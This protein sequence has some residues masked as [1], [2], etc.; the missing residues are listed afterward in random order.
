[1]IGEIRDNF[2]ESEYGTLVMRSYDI[3]GNSID[4]FYDASDDLVF[5]LDNTIIANK[6][7]VL[8]VI[9]PDADKKWDEILSEKYN[10]DLETIRP[11]QD[12][13]YQKLDIEYSGLA[14]YDNLINAYKAGDSLDDVLNQLNI[15][16]DSA[17]RH[18]AMTRLNV[19]NDTI[20]KTN[21]TIVK[22]KE[23]IVRLQ[24]RLKTLRAK[25]VDMKKEIGRVSTKKSAAKILRTESQIEATNEKLKRAKKRLES[26]QKRLE[27]ATVDAELASN[28]LNQPSMEIKQPVPVKNKPLVA[29][30]EHEV[31]MISEDAMLESENKAEERYEE[32]ETEE[33]ESDVKPLLEEDPNIVDDNIAFKPIEFNVSDATE[34]LP[35]D[36]K[37]NL[38]V[39]SEKSTENTIDNINAKPKPMLDAF[40]PIEEEKTSE[41][42][43]LSETEDFT[44]S[45]QPIPKFDFDTPTDNVDEFSYDQPEFSEKSKMEETTTFDTREPVEER[46]LTPIEDVVRPVPPIPVNKPEVPVV[47]DYPEPQKSK[48][49]SF[50]YYLLLIILIC[51]SVFTLWLYQQ[52]MGGNKPFGLV[53]E[54]D[55]VQEEQPVAERPV[56]KPEQVEEVEESVKEEE[57]EETAFLDEEEPSD[58]EPV[59]VEEPVVETQAEIIEEEPMIM[60]AV[61]AKISSF[62]DIQEPE[63]EPEQKLPTISEED[64]ILSKP[65]YGAGAKRNDMF[66][67]EEVISE[68][69]TES[70]VE[71]NFESSVI[72]QPADEEVV[73]QDEN[74]NT[75]E[76]IV[77]DDM[78]YDNTNPA[79]YDDEFFDAEEAAYQA[80]D[81]GYDEY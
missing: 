54:S 63:E 76:K 35:D 65:A 28:L 38:M 8:L 17:A 34:V 72:Y 4:A 64:I 49:S 7:N 9:N 12:N 77:Y 56:V 67:Y 78:N 33:F 14:V 30:P 69:P 73:Y 68:E 48:K 11:K 26:A 18:S 60:G 15:L 45:E 22:T 46:E 74:Q 41:D 24:E 27:T 58:A 57:P 19:A 42:F 40:V 16:R 37:L 55:V 25:L 10:V 43:N 6:P 47:Q 51:A 59:V 62:A 81:D 79:F 53:A 36:N 61:S 80:G 23:S 66:V 21:A 5:V 13:K 29:I 1:M 75:E 71:D 3:A 50:V 31:K 52:K 2:N 39:P 70:D 20:A 44:Q 32:E